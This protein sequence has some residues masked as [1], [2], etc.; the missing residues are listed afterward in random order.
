MTSQDR[1]VRQPPQIGGFEDTQEELAWYG[2]NPEG[3]DRDRTP[4]PFYSDASRSPSLPLK[5]LPTS[6]HPPLKRKASTPLDKWKEPRKGTKRIK[7]PPP[8]TSEVASTIL[9]LP[10]RTS[11]T[12]EA[13]FLL[14]TSIHWTAEQFDA[15]WPLVDN[16]WVCNKPNN[17]V[18]GKG[19]QSSYWWCRLHKGDT[20]SETHGQRNKALRRVDPCGM[21]LKMVKTYSQSDRSILLSV[22]ISLHLDK[23]YPCSEHNHERDYVDQCKINS[24]VM[25]AAGKAVAQGW[26]VH[27]VHS[28]LTALEAAGGRHLKL[29]DCYNAGTEWKKAHP[30]QRVQNVKAPWPEQWAG[31]LKDLKQV[32]EVLCANITAKRD[33]DDEMAYGT[34]FAK[35]CE[36]RVC[37]VSSVYA[38]G[39]MLARLMFL[40]RRGYLALMDFTHNSNALKWKLFT[41][42]ARS[43]HGKWIPCA[44]MLSPTEDGN[45]VGAFLRKIKDWCGGRGAWR[46]RY[47]ITDDSAQKA[48]RLAFRG[49]EEGEQQV[50]HF[51]CRKHSE[52]TLRLKLAGDICKA[53]FE[54]LYK[55]LYYRFSE[56]GCL[57]EIHAAIAKAPDSKKEYIRQWW[58]DTRRLWANYARQ[59]SCLLLQITTKNPVELWHHSLKI[60]AQ[61]KGAMLRFSLSEVASYTLKIADQWELREEEAAVSFRTQQS[62]E[63]ITYPQLARF[64]GPIQ[65]LIVGQLK[66][67]LEA[68]DEGDIT[69]LGEIPRNLNNELSCTC[70]FYRQYQLPCSHL[71]QFNLMS[72]EFTEADWNRW[73]YLFEEGGFEIYENITR[74]IYDEPDGPS[75][76]MLDV[77]EVLDEIKA[78]FYELEAGTAKWE[79]DVRE[80]ISAQWVAMLRQM[81]GPIRQRGA[82]EALQELANDG[83]NIVPPGW[84]D[85]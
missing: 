15:Y 31:V 59:H 29:T 16:F 75:K 72:N 27:S 84:K 74:D 30:D 42:M 38:D 64:P 62:A 81:T 28:N 83:H 2:S 36:F 73:A 7:S 46:L 5:S 35:K 69:K 3:I 60:H 79:D 68:Q 8:M 52:R 40:Q 80:R 54:H 24:F 25:N 47:M 76:H 51:L 10:E 66:K 11:D 23:K 77:R 71:W 61:G 63:C 48:V 39:I 65:K 4:E 55:A 50:D 53:S 82:Q 21:K 22:D 37:K 33:I 26:E 85:L 58:L 34:V 18:T 14:A 41:V 17:P 78:K 67:A 45:I 13:C 1:F 9:R 19:T 6:L 43:E 57:D 56:Q 44:H 70:L 32:E 49:L 12:R 20:V